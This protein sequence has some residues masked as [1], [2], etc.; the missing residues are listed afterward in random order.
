ML[1]A[2]TPPPEASQLPPLPRGSLCHP[3]FGSLDETPRW[4]K[5]FGLEGV[6]GKGPF[7]VCRGT[8]VKAQ[9]A[10]RLSCIT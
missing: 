3:G 5:R 1:L 4:V 8:P 10:T 7:E 9:R 2:P 6:G